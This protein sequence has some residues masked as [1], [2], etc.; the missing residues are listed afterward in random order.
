MRAVRLIARLRIDF[1]FTSSRRSFKSRIFLDCESSMANIALNDRRAI[2]LHSVRMERTFD[3][4][5]DGQFL[6]D[7][8]ALH[9]CAFGNHNCGGAQLALDPSK[10]SDGA[11][12]DNLAANRK[13]GTDRGDL[14]RRRGYYGRSWSWHLLRR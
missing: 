8:L 14:W 5:A 13:A 9:L 6:C 7:D 11:V 12:A 10:N 4:A 1:V 3:L 2:E